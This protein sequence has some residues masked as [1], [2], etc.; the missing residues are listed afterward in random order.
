MRF[1]L[2]M[3]VDGLRLDAIPYLIE[4]EGTNNENLPETHAVLKQLRAAIDAQLPEPLPARRGEPVA[5]GRAR[6]L[7]RRRRMPH[8]VPLPADAA[9]VHGDRPGG[10]LP[11][12][13]DHGADAG[14]PGELPVGDLPAQP[15]RADARDGDRAAS[16]TTCTRTYAADP[17]A[18]I[19]L[20]I[21]RRLAPLLENDMRP[22]QADEQPAAVACAAR[23][24]STTATRSA[25]ATTSSSATATACARRCSGARTATPASRAPTRSASTCRRSWTP[26]YGYEA[27]QRRGADARAVVAAQL[28]AAPARGAHGQ[29][30]V[31]ARHAD[32]PEAR[33]PQ[34]PRLPA[35]VRGRDASCASPTSRARRS[36]SSSTC[37]AFKGRVPV[38]L[39]GRTAFPP[40]G[41]L[42]YLLT[43]P[44]HGFYWF[45]LASDVAVPSWHDERLPA[46]EPAGARPLRRL[47]A[48]SFREQ[49]RAV[50][51]RHGE[52][53]RARSSRATRC[54][55]SSRRSAGMPAR[56]SRSPRAR[57]PTHAIWEAAAG[58]WRWSRRG[59]GRRGTGRTSCRSRSRWED[60]DEERLHAH[61]RLARG[62]R[63]PAGA[64]SACWPT[65]SPTRPSAAPWSAAIGAARAA[66]LGGR[67]PLRGRRAPSRESPADDVDGAAG[68]P[69]A[70][71]RAATPSSPSAIACS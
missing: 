24:S 27:R 52:R 41:E 21:R 3:G 10:P 45:R 31:R 26:V 15:R 56:A 8:G 53:R 12:H 11:D 59:R 18:R 40:I 58:C 63:A 20:G 28:D 66:G 71:A 57:S 49:R 32:V 50:A 7:R 39:L 4:R 67:L 37:R 34:D 51:H 19:N 70:G 6:V 14:H 69:A 9:H 16:A 5:R 42:P 65:R 43:L 54:R 25:W 29:P 1:W 62:A 44:A 2:D 36:R 55:A 46:E 17:R 38:E 23:R 68:R 13:R 22:H 33:Q 47:D 48:A 35:R 64:R 30:R 60:R 61:G